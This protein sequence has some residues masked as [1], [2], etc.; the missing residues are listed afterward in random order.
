MATDTF[1]EY[2]ICIAFPRQQWLQFEIAGSLSSG[3]SHVLWN[4]IMIFSHSTQYNEIILWC[5]SAWLWSHTQRL[6]SFGMLRSM[7][8]Q[9]DINVLEEPAASFFTAPLF[10]YDFK[11]LVSRNSIK[12]SYI[13]YS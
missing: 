11:Y 8:L 3:I 5:N 4:N 7:L 13:L 10:W 6:Q 2:E 1:C 9:T 12:A